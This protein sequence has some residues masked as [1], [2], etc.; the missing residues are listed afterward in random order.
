[1]LYLLPPCTAEESKYDEIY[2]L[3][4]Q[5]NY[6]LQRTFGSSLVNTLIKFQDNDSIEKPIIA[7][8]KDFFNNHNNRIFYFNDIVLLCEYFFSRAVELD[9]NCAIYFELLN[10][11]VSL[12]LIPKSHQSIEHITQT[13]NGIID[14]DDLKQQVGEK[15]MEC[16]DNLLMVL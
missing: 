7:F 9:D 16:I 1:M 5:S 12:N 3:I 10:E 15:G 6:R 13:L 14:R 11:V 4:D 2:T 8:L